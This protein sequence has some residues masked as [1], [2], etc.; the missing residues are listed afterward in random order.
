LRWEV[1]GLAAEND[2]DFLYQAF[3][4]LKSPDEVRRFLEDI[5]TIGELEDLTQRLAVARLL[6]EGR[7]YEEVAMATGVS[8]TTISRVRRFL[9]HGADGYRLVL[10]RLGV[11]QQ[12]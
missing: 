1:S 10:E 4:V 9:F 6:Y 3:T 12:G 2:A 11:R 5:L 8:N 7:T